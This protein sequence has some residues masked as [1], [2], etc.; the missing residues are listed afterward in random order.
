MRARGI[1]SRLAVSRNLVEANEESVAVE[2]GE[3]RASTFTLTRR[4]AEVES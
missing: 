1:A 4:T 2:T 3:S